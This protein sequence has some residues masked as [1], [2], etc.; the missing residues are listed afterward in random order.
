MQLTQ[1]MGSMGVLNVKLGYHYKALR[2]FQ[3]VARIFGEIG[4]ESMVAQSYNLIG[5]VYLRMGEYDKTASIMDK[6][7]T[8]FRKNNNML[9]IANVYLTLSEMSLIDGKYQEGIQNLNKA[10]EMYHE[11][12]IKP[13]ISAN[14][15]GFS[16]HLVIQHATSAT[17]NLIKIRV[18]KLHPCFG[19]RGSE[20]QILS[21]RQF[22]TMGYGLGRSP[23][24]VVGNTMGNK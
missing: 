19:S 13:Q 15:I 21:P 6:A 5:S 11:R 2:N 7:L 17:V 12:S 9:G 18:N 22:K 4:N 3:Q 8:I 10:L 14:M 16:W 20:V 23:F 24:F 1:V